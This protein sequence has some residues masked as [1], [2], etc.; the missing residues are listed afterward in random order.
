[1]ARQNGIP[2]RTDRLVD[3]FIQ[4]VEI[5]S[6]SFHER[7]MADVLTQKLQQ[8]GFTVQE[9]DAAKQFGGEAGNLYAYLPGTLPGE[10][11]LFSSHMDTVTPGIGKRAVLYEDGR[12]TSAGDTVL[13]SDDV[14]GIVSILEAI[15]TLQENNIPRR[16]LEVLFTFAEEPYVKGCYAFDFSK[17]RSR[18]A[19]GLD[20][21]GPVGR[22]SLQEPTLISY[23][24]RITGKAS[25]AGFA[26]EK[27][28]NAIAAAAQAI[29]AIQQG[30]IDEETTVNI[31]KIT[32]GQLTNIVP[33][34]AVVEGEVRSYSHEK[35]LAQVREIRRA[36]EEAAKAFDADIE[37]KEEICLYAYRVEPDEPVVKRFQNV[38]KELG[39]SGELTRTCGGSDNNAFNR[40]GLHGIVLACGMNEVHSTRE[41]TTRDELTRC[42]AIVAG[43][44]SSEL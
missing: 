31:G 3:E 41:Y 25:H 9:D 24:I 21:S 5:D 4:L 27:G 39:L 26:P 44:M 42:A 6:V 19:Y 38:C 22:A 18:Q 15:R 7:K 40:N 11:L 28:V 23:E 35:A 2:I 10:P 1:M 34:L 30:R 17:V 43:L 16:D 14:A 37:M 32:G 33:E 20:I 12:I 8:L 36:F 29:S 13:G